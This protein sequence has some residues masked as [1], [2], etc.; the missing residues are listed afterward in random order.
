MSS[1]IFVEVARRAA[2]EVTK[3]YV[4]RELATGAAI[5]AAFDGITSLFSG[6]NPVKEGAKGAAAGAAGN[7]AA[8]VLRDIAHQRSPIVLAGSMLAS[9]GAR[10]AIN[11]A[12]GK[13]TI[14]QNDPGEEIIGGGRK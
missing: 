7:G 3:E 2:K 13:V 14:K 9:I 12:T 4:L 5:G 8:V 1:Q 11:I 10:Y 6:K